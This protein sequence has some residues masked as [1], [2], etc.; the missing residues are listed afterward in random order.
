VV[1]TL[2]AIPDAGSF[3]ELSLRPAA[4]KERP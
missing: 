3:Q 2:L 4:G 1:V